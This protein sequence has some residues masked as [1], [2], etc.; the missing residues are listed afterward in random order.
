MYTVITKTNHMFTIKLEQYPRMSRWMRG[1]VV[2]EMSLKQIITFPWKH[3]LEKIIRAWAAERFAIDHHSIQL[4]MIQSIA[5]HESELRIRSFLHSMR[6]YDIRI[7]HLRT[8]PYTP[9]MIKLKIS[10]K[11]PSKKY[12]E[13][14]KVVARLI[15]F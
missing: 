14:I 1:S 15:I 12:Y 2:K 5:S 3:E 13:S 11:R 10:F 9:S 4:P 7:I 6:Y 8:H